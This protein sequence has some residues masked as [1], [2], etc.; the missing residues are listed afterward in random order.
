MK[1]VE[2]KI[3][4]G[5]FLKTIIRRKKLKEKIEENFNIPWTPLSTW[6]PCPRSLNS[7]FSISLELIS[8]VRPQA[9]GALILSVAY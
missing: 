4:V 3:I 5:W 9:I 8:M 1:N 2:Y 6:S 7:R